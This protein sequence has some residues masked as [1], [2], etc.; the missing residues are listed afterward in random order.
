[1]IIVWF[2]IFIVSLA[3][4]VKAADYFTHYSEKVALSLKISPFIIGVTLI[5]FGTSLP[6]LATA[7][8]AVF[9]GDTTIAIANAFGSNIA[10]IFLVLGFVAYVVKKLKAERNLIDIDLPLLFLSTALL[11]I[12]VMDRIVTTGEGIILLV[13]YG[14][15]LTYVIK[16][17]DFAKDALPK[18]ADKPLI[19]PRIELSTLLFII[20]SILGIYLGAE[21]TV[22]SVIELGSFFGISTSVIAISAIAIGTSLPELVI[23]LR[24]ALKGKH[25]IAIGNIVGSNIFNALIVVGIPS[26]FGALKVDDITWEIG[27]P[28]LIIATLTFIFSGITKRVYRYEGAMYLVIYV[29]FLLKIFG[30]F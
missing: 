27:F 3:V 5:A 21:F 8:V 29:L 16:S 25:D 12:V 26:L 19:R 22:R 18:L 20:L 2:F 23:S 10:N 30:F 4:L 24:A 11:V 9:R 28:F 6:E 17:Q 13:G 15:Y 1:M 14:V 7:V